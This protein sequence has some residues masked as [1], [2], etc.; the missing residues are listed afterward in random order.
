MV[1]KL[2]FNGVNSL[3]HDNCIILGTADGIYD[4]LLLGVDD[5]SLDRES[6]W[7]LNFIL[8]GVKFG[9]NPINLLGFDEGIILGI[10]Y[11]LDGLLFGADS[12]LFDR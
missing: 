4:C 3:G 9:V 10:S 2:G 1:I 8:V 7:A 11:G 5:E 6:L 12:R